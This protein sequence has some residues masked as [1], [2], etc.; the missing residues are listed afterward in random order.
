MPYNGE[1]IMKKDN[2]ILS[3]FRTNWFEPPMDDLLKL[4]D[5]LY[6]W[7]ISPYVLNN[8]G[9]L[10]I[11]LAID[12]FI[13]LVVWVLNTAF[14][15]RSM[16]KKI[17]KPNLNPKEK[18]HNNMINLFLILRNWMMWKFTFVFVLMHFGIL[19]FF[20]WSNLVFPNLSS[21]R[22]IFNFIVS[23]ILKLLQCCFYW[24]IF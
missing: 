2:D 10:L 14:T 1:M 22:G 19:S 6:A 15:N 18:K 9:W 11:W 8:V 12:I 20:T 17:E 7:D 13:G 4:K 5:R 16:L 3:V 24:F 23:L 21:G